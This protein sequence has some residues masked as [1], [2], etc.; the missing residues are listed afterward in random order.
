MSFHQKTN[1]SLCAYSETTVHRQTCRFTRTRTNLSAL[2]QKEQ[3]TNRHVVSLEHEPICL[4]LL[5]NNSPQVDMS[6]HQRTS[7]LSVLTQ[8]QQSTCRYVVSLEHEPICLCLLKSNCPQVDMSFHQNRSQYVCSY[9]EITVHMQTCRFTRRRANLCVL[10]QK[11]QSTGRLV[12]SLEHEPI[13]LCLLRNNNPRVDMSFHYNMSQSVCAY[14][15]TTV[16]WKT[17]RFTRTRATCLC[18]IRN[19]SP[20]VEMSFH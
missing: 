8:K 14:S 5:R 16:H 11:Q 9:S 17:C 3:S 15:E 6:F 7:N 2:A 12:V 18:L 20:Q 13:C 1:Q 4:C 19:N 10:T